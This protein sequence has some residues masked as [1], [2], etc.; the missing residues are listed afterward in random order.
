MD[1]DY[2]AEQL[3]EKIEASVVTPFT[4]SSRPQDYT[5]GHLSEYKELTY[6]GSYTLQHIFSQFLEGNQ[7]GLRGHLMR[8]VLDDLAPEA[9]LRLYAETGQ[10][11]FDEWKAAAVRVSEQH[12]MDWIEENQPAIW[13]LLQMIG[14]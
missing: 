3:F 10:E 9:R 11:Y 7:I 14:E 6:Y 13:L 1:T 4:A 12:D 5:A 2:V 8:E